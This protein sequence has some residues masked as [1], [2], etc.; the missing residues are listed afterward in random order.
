MM[1][2]T[3]AFLKILTGDVLDLC[4]D[5]HLPGHKLGDQTPPVENRSCHL[6]VPEIIST[7]GM[8]IIFKINL[9][10]TRAH[11]FSRARGDSSD[12]SELKFLMGGGGVLKVFKGR[13]NYFTKELHPWEVQCKDS[14]QERG[15][16]RYLSE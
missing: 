13:P 7:N 2:I 8:A 11:I 6:H 16:K 14:L 4:E 10:H 1:T 15:R 3:N 9:S 5:L 12:P